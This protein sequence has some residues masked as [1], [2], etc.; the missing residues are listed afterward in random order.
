M[1]WPLPVLSIFLIAL[2]LL[3]TGAPPPAL[4]QAT[5]PGKASL[6]KISVGD[7]SVRFR[8]SAAGGLADGDTIRIEYKQTTTTSWT[9]ASHSTFTH[10]A[11]TIDLNTG[12]VTAGTETGTVTGLDQGAAYDFRARATNSQG[13]GAWSDTITVA[14]RPGSPR[15]LSATAS[16]TAVSVNV[17]WAAPSSN[18]G[19]DITGYT[20]NWRPHHATGNWV[21]RPPTGSRGVGSATTSVDITAADGLAAGTNYDFR[22]SAT[23]ADRRSLWTPE[24]GSVAARTLA[25]YDIDDDGLI[26]VS[27]LEQ[28]GAINWDPD[29]DGM[30]ADDART[31]GINEAD[32]YAAAF[33]NAVANQCGSGGCAG[34]ELARDLDFNDPASYAAGQV[35]SAWTTG[36][37]W[38]SD[39]GRGHLLHRHLRRQSPHHLQPVFQP[40]G[41]RF[42]GPVR[43]RAR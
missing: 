31:T 29:G 16:T 36:L 42:S 17:R 23:N 34:Y 10:I 43:L 7:G 24:N 38:E 21:D 27:T 26:E 13:D 14:G 25:D 3:L 9:G 15:N 19:G 6:A 2:G 12:E 4:A 37:G 20:I 18:G 22:I 8:W 30:V 32:E 1:K 35:S 5:V 33:P 41:L 40:A 28:L 11:P 39:R